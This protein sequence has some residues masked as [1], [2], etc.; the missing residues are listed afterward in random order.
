MCESFRSVWLTRW[1]LQGI[2]LGKDLMEVAG[3]ALRANMTC[4]APRVLPWAEQLRY[5]H[6]LFLRKVHVDLQ[7]TLVPPHQE[8]TH[9]P[10]PLVCG[11]HMAGMLLS[12][13]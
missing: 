3:H 4:L 6:N 9:A 11:S 2:R 13:M 5:L 1:F 12:A 10:M 8:L 7:S